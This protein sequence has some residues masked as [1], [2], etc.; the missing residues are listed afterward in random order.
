[1][2]IMLSANILNIKV[3]HNK[4]ARNGTRL[5]MLEAWSMIGWDLI[6][7]DQIL[8]SCLLDNMPYW[9]SPYTSS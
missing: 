2:L 7:G 1:M 4:G 5:V 3:V 8:V 9:G 6:K